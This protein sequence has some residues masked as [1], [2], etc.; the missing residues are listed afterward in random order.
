MPARLGWKTCCE[1]HRDLLVT[2]FYRHPGEEDGF[3]RH[4]K[5]CHN[6][7]IDLND[8]VR[9]QTTERLWG[10]PT[11][12]QIRRAAAEVRAGWSEKTMQKRRRTARVGLA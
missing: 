2:K 12:E 3:M 8:R 5:A 11:E 9:P 1:C 7:C 6:G 10:D 4:C